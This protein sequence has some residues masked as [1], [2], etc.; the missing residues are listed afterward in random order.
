MNEAKKTIEEL[1]SERQLAVAMAKRDF[2]VQ[3]EARDEELASCRELL[4]QAQ[5]ENDTVK[6]SLEQARHSGIV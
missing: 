4:R 6:L 3:L 5:T 1:N 2:H